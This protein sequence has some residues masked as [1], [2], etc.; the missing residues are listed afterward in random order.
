MILVL[1]G[2]SFS[3][4]DSFYGKD[5]I[6]GINLTCQESWPVISVYL[7]FEHHKWCIKDDQHTGVGICQTE[8]FV[9]GAV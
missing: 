1:E 4:V 6:V 9:D 8:C 5:V 3:R 7:W 2:T